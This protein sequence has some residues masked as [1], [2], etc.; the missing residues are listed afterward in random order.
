LPGE[1]WTVRQ[2]AA[3]AVASGFGKPLGE[4]EAEFATGRYGSNPKMVS[5]PVDVTNTLPF[6]TTGTLNFAAASRLSRDPLASL[7]Y[8]SRFRFEAS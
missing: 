5:R 3:V 1:A 8:S 7:L 2:K 6:A 4:T